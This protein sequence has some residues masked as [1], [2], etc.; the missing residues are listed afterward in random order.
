ME[1]R[2]PDR[3]TENAD[4][5]YIQEVIDGGYCIGCGACAYVTK[6]AM[7]M[8]WTA[9]GRLQPSMQR[10]LTDL[11]V[12]SAWAVCPFANNGADEE[13]I[14]AQLFP[15]QPSHEG[16]GKTLATLSGSVTSPEARWASSSGGIITWLLSTMLE[17]GMVD[18]VVH[19][20]PVDP[21]ES[22]SEL[23][24]FRVST[25]PHHVAEGA[26]SHYYPV[27]MQYVL[28]EIS[29]SNLERFAITGVPCFIKALRLL[30]RTD[31]SISN[32]LT[33]MIGLVCGHLKSSRFADLLSWQL[34]IPPGNLAT[35]DF[36]EKLPGR[37]ANRYGIRVKGLSNAGEPITTSAPM[38]E[39]EGAD[40]GIGYFRYSA[41]NY[42]DDVFAETADI[43]VGD[44][45]LPRYVRDSNGTSVIVIRRPELFD[46]MTSGAA[47]GEL[48]LEP[49]TFQD[50]LRSQE[51][52]LRDRRSGL[53]YRLWVKRKS[54]TWV[55]RKRVPARPYRL[56]P[57]FRR[58][59]DLRLD[60]QYRIAAAYEEELTREQ[61]SIEHLTRTLREI[62]AEYRKH[63]N[64]PFERVKRVVRRR[65]M[66]RLARYGI[67]PAD[68]IFKR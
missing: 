21:G 11:D 49:M 31:P 59:Q 35:I 67:V 7:S 61:P 47:K 32:K 1:V 55:P 46:L 6:G 62:V 52:G 56:D 4:L 25:Q 23:V 65:L 19:V 20:R 34:G 33:Y 45:W 15:N 54:G 43:T 38:S 9:D 29:N 51:G 64:A 57:W 2:G 10:C 44:A 63:Y 60:V 3:G 17:Q 26:K 40:W 66:P 58:L 53:A 5:G 12:R 39:L 16:L 8:K 13:S 36:R 27:T 50:A 48:R 37:P 24:A 18:A 14:A 41:C 68:W 28:E 30:S 22:W 42:C